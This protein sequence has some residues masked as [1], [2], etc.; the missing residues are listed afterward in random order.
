MAQILLELPDSLMDQ[1][2]LLCR[3]KGQD[4]AD[5]LAERLI[6]LWALRDLLP[7]P[8]SE[9]SLQQLTDEEVLEL[10][11]LK[12]EA[13]Q[14]HRLGELQA[15]GKAQTLNQ[16]EEIELSVLLQIYQLGQLR[17]SEGLSEV[18]RRGLK[19]PLAA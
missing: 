2:S 15:Q 18:V 17:K 14:N 12:M 4:L 10:A 11:D 1:A 6:Q 19:Q 16:L 13:S 7:E 9:V 3:E 8:L 5:L